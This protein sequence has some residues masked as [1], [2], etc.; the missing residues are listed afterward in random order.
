MLLARFFAIAVAPRLC[1][2]ALH[3]GQI[4]NMFSDRGK[5]AAPL[6]LPSPSSGLA[7]DRT[8][9]PIYLRLWAKPADLL[10]PVSITPPTLTC[11]IGTGA[12]NLRLGHLSSTM[13]PEACGS[14]SGVDSAKR[15]LFGGY[16][17]TCP[18]RWTSLLLLDMLRL[19][20]F[21]RTFRHPGTTVLDTLSADW[22]RW[23]K[24]STIYL[25]PPPVIVH[26]CPQKP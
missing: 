17:A 5:H 18:L 23:S 7:L 10:Y 8:Q 9:P 14:W 16:Y 24:F 22:N 26:L 19:P 2:P 11:S 12:S 21:W 1:G 4:F 6:H 3:I 15:P 20:L 13:M 25:F